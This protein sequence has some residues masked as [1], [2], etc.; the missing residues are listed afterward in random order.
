MTSQKPILFLKE[1]DVEIM[2][3]ADACVTYDT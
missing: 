3:M 1:F 2:L